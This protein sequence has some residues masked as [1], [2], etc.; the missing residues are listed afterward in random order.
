[1]L[2]RGLRILGKAIREEPRIF[3]ISVVG[4]GGFGLLTIGGAYVV[5]AVVGDIVVPSLEDGRVEN[6]V[7]FLA[8]AVLVALSLLKVA[9]IFARRLGAAFMQFR[10]QAAYRR[11]VTRRYLELP[12]AWHQRNATGT[13][14]S[15]ANSDVEATWFPIAPLPFAV[16]TLIMLLGAFVS[17][18]ATDWV[19]ALVGAAIFPALFALNVVY[20]RRMAPARLA[21]RPSAAR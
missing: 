6:G 18:F 7:L 1:M 10:L 12:V 17:L 5:G 13:L 16:G 19:L 4:S 2:V 9:A 21:P 14:L 11:R 3:A 20:S 15:N 8:A